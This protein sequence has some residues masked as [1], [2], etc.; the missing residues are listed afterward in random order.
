VDRRYFV[1][2]LTS[3]SRNLYTGMTS[4]LMRRICEHREGRVPGF[5][6][7]Y[8]IQRLVRVASF[9]DVREAIGR[10]K[11]IKSWR[12]ELRLK[13]MEAENPAWRDLAEERL[14]A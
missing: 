11:Q 8:R 6:S 7:R 10:K 13:L 1:Y 3:R 2:I 14:A 12:R 9:R 5:T 4:D